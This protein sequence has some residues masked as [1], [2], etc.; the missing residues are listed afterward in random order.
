MSP[1]APVI[2]VGGAAVLAF[3]A[4]ASLA[5]R[6]FGFAYTSAAAGSWVI[7]AVVGFL[8]GRSAGLAV[9]A[10][11]GAAMGFVDATLGWYVS[12]QIGPGRVAGG[13]T[14]SRWV[15]AAVTVTLLAAAIGALGGLAARLLAAD[16][17]ARGLTL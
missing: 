7:Y 9:A 14:V 16:A 2:L 12:W 1:I 11:A 8:A 13:L 3:D 5:S 17:A 15:T 4:A 6:R 10:P